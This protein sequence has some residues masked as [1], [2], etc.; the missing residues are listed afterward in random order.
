MMDKNK[1]NKTIII[2]VLIS[3]I[4]ILCGITL[5][6]FIRNKSLDTSKLNYE[7]EIKEDHCIDDICIKNMKVYYLQNEYNFSTISATIENKGNSSLEMIMLEI[8]FEGSNKPFIYYIDK[9]D[10]NEKKDINIQVN[11][12]EQDKIKNYSF[13]YKKISKEELD[14]MTD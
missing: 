4:L 1:S 6:I 9:I 10:K 8:K 7:E 3:I 13:T 12:M 14:K 11:K 5:S 2:F